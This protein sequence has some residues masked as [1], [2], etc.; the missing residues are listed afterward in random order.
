MHY[1][2]FFPTTDKWICFFLEN[3]C[4]CIEYSMI[5]PNIEIPEEKKNLTWWHVNPL[6]VNFIIHQDNPIVDHLM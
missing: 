3:N 5:K 2:G 4:I 6:I 1:G